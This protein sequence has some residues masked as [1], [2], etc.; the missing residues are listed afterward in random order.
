MMMSGGLLGDEAVIDS[1]ELALQ[2]KRLAI[3]ELEGAVFSGP[4]VVWDHRVGHALD[5]C[6]QTPRRLG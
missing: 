3:C 2:S 5:A 6:S 1:V 4:F